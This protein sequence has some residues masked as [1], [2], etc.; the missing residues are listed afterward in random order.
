[1]NL[2]E[3]NSSLPKPWLNPQFNSVITNEIVSKITLSSASY[4]KYTAGASYMLP[5]ESTVNGIVETNFIIN[6]KLPS[7][8]DLDNYL[9]VAG[10]VRF[11]L[12]LT[13]DSSGTINFIFSSGTVGFNGDIAGTITSNKSILLYYQRKGLNNWVIYPLIST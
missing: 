2:Q 6:L 7:G 11:D 12:L 9:N 8:S 1:M 5:V 10:N 4:T 13:T 3:L